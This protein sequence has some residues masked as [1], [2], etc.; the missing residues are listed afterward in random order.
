MATRHGHQ[1]IVLLAHI[2]RIRAHFSLRRW[3]SLDAT[4]KESDALFGTDE[5][6][7]SGDPATA[8]FR[9]VLLMHYLNMRALHHGR[10]ADDPAAKKQLNRLYPLMDMALDKGMVTELRVSGG[11]A[12]VSPALRSTLTD[13]FLCGLRMALRRIFWSSRRPSACCGP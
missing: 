6:I 1:D 13:R 7:H 10:A 2:I 3:D 12:T 4:L 9:L 5:V 8:S 11:L